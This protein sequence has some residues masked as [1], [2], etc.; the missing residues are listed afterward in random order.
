MIPTVFTSSFHYFEGPKRVYSAAVIGTIASIAPTLGPVIGG[1]ITDAV[2]WHWL[3]YV[4]LLPGAAITAAVPFLIDIDKPDLSLLK[5]AE[6]LGIALMAVDLG[7]PEY[8]VEEGTRWNWFDD[9]TLR[10]A[11]RNRL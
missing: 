7:T 9:E 6:Y 10:H 3:F 8:T 1:W 4:N 2:D 11:P 5:G